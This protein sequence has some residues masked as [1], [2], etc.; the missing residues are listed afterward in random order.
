MIFLYCSVGLRVSS[1][2][3]DVT[4]RGVGCSYGGGHVVVLGRGRRVTDTYMVSSS[5]RTFRRSDDP[6]SPE[7]E[8]KVN[9]PS[10]ILSIR[11]Y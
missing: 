4:G 9:T 6:R 11:L 5:L 3:V 7:K 10:Q 2:G 8:Q 1:A